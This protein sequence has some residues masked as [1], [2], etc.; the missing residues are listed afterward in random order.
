VSDLK[1]S[2]ILL[3]G[4]GAAALL[5]V[6][7][8]TTRGHERVAEVRTWAGHSWRVSG[9]VLERLST[10]V[11]GEEEPPVDRR[12]AFHRLELSVA[13]SGEVQSG[14]PGR[15]RVVV[16]AQGSVDT[17]TLYQGGTEFRVSLARVRELLFARQAVARSPLPPYVAAAH[18]RHTVTV[19]MTDGS[20]VEGDYV[21][22]GATVFRGTARTGRVEIPW[23]EIE[24]VRF[25]R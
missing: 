5:A 3:A 6:G 7:A 15:R 21:N 18:V 13:T 1:R 10:I 20:R 9:P 17:L 11:I 4:F 16:Q 14:Q 22:L 8:G 2:R 19:V 23:E 25:L 12:R 24:S